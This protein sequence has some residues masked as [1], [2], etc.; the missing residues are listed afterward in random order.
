MTDLDE[1]LLR[2]FLQ[3]AGAHHGLE[4]L[5]ANLGLSSRETRGAL[6]DLQEAGCPI[7]QHP[8]YG[9]RL[10]GEPATLMGD[11]MAAQIRERRAFWEIGVF[12]Q[13]R[14]TNDLIHRLGA[15]GA[16]EGRVVF[17]ESQTAGRG[18]YGRA[19]SGAPGKALLF[20]CL[21]R[22][23][24]PRDQWTLL[25]PMTAVALCRAL[26][27]L[28]GG[29][30]KIKW[31]NDLWIQG[32]K[33]GGILT[34]LNRDRHGEW[35]AVTGIGLNVGQTAEDFPDELRATAISVFQAC[36]EP[37]GRHRLAAS[38]LEQLAGLYAGMVTPSAR[39]SMLDEYRGRSA[40]MRRRV[41][42]RVGTEEISGC[43]HGFD[44]AGGMTLETETGLRTLCSGEI[45]R[46]LPDHAPAP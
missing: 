19:W 13:T 2:C 9:W 27:G 18:R 24:W 38:A 10:T 23:I 42:A 17:A 5:A 36:G 46:V 41:V 35:F 44:L 34:E 37:V 30:M 25:T 3:N 32:R 39:E 22:P 45:T 11:F 4:E 29:A 26:D 20:S 15:A 7:E 14:S 31:P 8:H 28:T 33:V 43:V 40:L 12:R 16:G 21:F 1:K 6:R